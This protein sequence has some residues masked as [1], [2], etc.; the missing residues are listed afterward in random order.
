MFIISDNINMFR[1]NSSFTSILILGLVNLELW[2]IIIPDKKSLVTKKAS[3]FGILLYF[4]ISTGILFP[5]IAS[6]EACSQ[7]DN[8]LQPLLPKSICSK[9]KITESEQFSI[10]SSLEDNDI[11]VSIDTDFEYAM[12]NVDTYIYYIRIYA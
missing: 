11:T 8:I 7:N 2:F 10:V 9:R 1:C 3:P 4:I 5:L 12:E 6:F